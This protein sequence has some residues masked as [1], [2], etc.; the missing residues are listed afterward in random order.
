VA[1]V[2]ARF[3]GVKSFSDADL[4]AG[5]SLLNEPSGLSGVGGFVLSKLG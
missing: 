2:K 3:G 5:A 1:R 4:S